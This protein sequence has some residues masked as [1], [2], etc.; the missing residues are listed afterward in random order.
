MTGYAREVGQKSTGWNYASAHDRGASSGDDGGAGSEGGACAMG[1]YADGGVDD[2]DDG[3]ASQA[4]RGQLCGLYCSGDH[5]PFCG[6][7]RALPQMIH[8]RNGDG[9]DVHGAAWAW[10]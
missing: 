6:L 2:P 7:G 9:E 4:R 1:E 3:G 8:R 10:G 5:V